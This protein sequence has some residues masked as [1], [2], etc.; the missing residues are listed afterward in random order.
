MRI[1]TRP[2]YVILDS[3]RHSPLFYV[4]NFGRLIKDAEGYIESCDACKRSKELRQPR[5]GLIRPFP[6]PKKKWEI[7]SV[8]FVFD[9]PV[10][11]FDKFGI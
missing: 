6:P 1:K 11:S 4:R 7:I 2:C 3:P 10:T 5:G 9:F 8:D